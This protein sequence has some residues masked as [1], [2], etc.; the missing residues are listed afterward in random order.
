MAKYQASHQYTTH[1]A[2]IDAKDADV[3]DKIAKAKNQ[4]EN[5]NWLMLH[6]VKETGQHF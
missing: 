4:E 6:K 1:L 5:Q 3:S 2:E